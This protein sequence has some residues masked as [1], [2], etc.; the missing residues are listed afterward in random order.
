MPLVIVWFS[1]NW[2]LLENIQCILIL[3]VPYHIKFSFFFFFCFILLIFDF[4]LKHFAGFIDLIHFLSRF[5]G[6][7]GIW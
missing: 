1:S 2:G 3:P 6:G 5:G 4:I 7:S